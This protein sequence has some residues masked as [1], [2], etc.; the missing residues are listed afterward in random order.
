MKIGGQIDSMECHNFL[1]N[2]QDLL[3]DG[4][5]HTKDVLENKKTQSFCLVHWLSI[6]LLL[7][8]ISQ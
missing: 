3:S 1:R 2:I 7:R 6:T 5:F 8:K 4:K